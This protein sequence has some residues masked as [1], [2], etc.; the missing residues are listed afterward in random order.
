MSKK[1]IENAVENTATE[2][3]ATENTTTAIVNAVNDVYGV[4]SADTAIDTVRE[5]TTQSTA[6]L[7]NALNGS[8]MSIKSI[9]GECRDIT[10]IV[11]TSAIVNK[12]INDNSADAEKVNTPVVHFYDTD[13]NHYSS[14][15][16][17][18]VRS[19]KNLLSTG[20]V[21]TPDSPVRI[22]FI[23]VETKRGIA[24]TFELC[25]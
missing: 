22:K 9:L 2:S 20:I 13:G 24:H 18:I 10:D 19:V 15:S 1:V 8:A 5:S 3:Q 11:V 23:T 4:V 21:P 17:G 7:F 25:D 12:D 6:K 14:I 16:H